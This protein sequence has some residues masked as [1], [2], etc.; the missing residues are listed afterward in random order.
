MTAIFFIEILRVLLRVIDNGPGDAYLSTL[1]NENY[2]PLIFLIDVLHKHFA[3][4]K[5]SFLSNFT[6]LS[7][8]F[9]LTKH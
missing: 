3:F 1:A 9:K 8:T 7:E 6:K 4:N 5:K 2:L